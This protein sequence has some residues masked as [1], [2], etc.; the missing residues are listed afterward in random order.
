M[1]KK[2]VHFIF[3]PKAETLYTFSVNFSYF[4]AFLEPSH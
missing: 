1:I 3:S 2:K 4:Y